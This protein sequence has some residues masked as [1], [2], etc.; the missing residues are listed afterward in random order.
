MMAPAGVISED[1]VM[2]VIRAHARR[3]PTDRALAIARLTGV[4]YIITGLC[5][6]WLTL[7]T[8]FVD[9]FAARGR[10]VSSETA[11]HALGWLMALALP[12]ICLIVGTHHIL[13]FAELQNP[14][15]ARRDP[16]AG[17]GSSLGQDYVA[18][19]DMTLPGGRQVSSLLVGPP[20]IV[21][22]G[23]VPAATEARQIDGRWEARVAN[24]QWIA[25]E[26]PLER[27]ARDADAVR[28]WLAAGEHGFVVKVYA[29][30]LASDESVA[31]NATTAVVARGQIPAFLAKL[32]PHRT[33]TSARRRQVLDRIR[34]AFE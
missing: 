20:G 5:M 7:A 29:A 12:T 16:L 9:V 34:G 24:D 25:I 1:P 22:L 23:R 6:A 11:F 21:V 13:D 4:L 15:A 2:E 10:A 3:R 26:N 30:V 8:P 17:I 27:V 33:F 18:V 32:P 31:R 14:F 19:R 28:R